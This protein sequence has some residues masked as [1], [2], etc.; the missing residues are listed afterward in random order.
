[1]QKIISSGSAC[2]NN[3]YG[4][5]FL[6]T[7]VERH[8]DSTGAEMTS[9]QW[10]HQI[11]KAVPSGRLID[12]R[13]LWY[14]KPKYMCCSTWPT[15]C[16]KHT[17]HNHKLTW[18]YGQWHSSFI[19]IS[20]TNVICISKIEKETSPHSVVVFKWVVQVQGGISCAAAVLCH[21]RILKD[22]TKGLE[23]TLGVDANDKV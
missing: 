7:V 20:Q 9:F 14:S 10:L 15:V 1:M 13:V 12:L 6:V 8:N 19:Y 5:I 3:Y 23:I 17:Q 4:E 11:V 18:S 22:K 16:H 21:C 2:T